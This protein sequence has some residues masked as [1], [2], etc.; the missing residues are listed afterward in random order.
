M[1]GTL[2]FER[3]KDFAVFLVVFGPG[4][5]GTSLQG[6]KAFP[7]AFSGARTFLTARTGRERRR[8]IHHERHE[9]APRANDEAY[10]RGERKRRIHEVTRK[11]NEYGTAKLTRQTKRRFTRCLLLLASTVACPG[12]AMIAR[13]PARLHSPICFPPPLQLV[14]LAFALALCRGSCFRVVEARGSGWIGFGVDYTKRT[15]LVWGEN[16]IVED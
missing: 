12:G 4:L 13:L 3:V 8:G 11:W 16:W 1:V 10:Q 14:P 5:V 2:P 15:Q 7:A 9:R 6:S